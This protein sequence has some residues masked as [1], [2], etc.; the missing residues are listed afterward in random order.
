MGRLSAQMQLYIGMGLLLV[1]T[2]AVTFL[3]ILPVYQ[4]SA[5]LQSQIKAEEGNLATAK[6][7]LARRQ[8]AKVQSASNEIELMRVANQLPDSPQLP[9]V[10]IEIQDLANSADLS[11]QALSPSDISPVVDV[12]TGADAGYSEVPMTLQLRG[13]WADFITFFRNLAALDRGVRIESTTLT[14]VPGDEENDPY[15]D[16][17]VGIKVY[18]MKA[19]ATD[20]SPAATAT[21]AGAQQTGTTTNP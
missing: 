21:P 1:I 17:T 12:T 7:L 10:I 13:D 11:L 19:A 3:V 6:A 5:T 18:V 16:G 15:M 2:L 14:Y 9:S 20:K 4:Q 8:S